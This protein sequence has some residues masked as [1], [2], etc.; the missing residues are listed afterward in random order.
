MDTDEGG[1]AAG[2]PQN[3]CWGRRLTNTCSSFGMIDLVRDDD[4]WV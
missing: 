1:K 3:P 4:V 2:K